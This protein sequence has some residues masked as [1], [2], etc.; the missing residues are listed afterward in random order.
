[1]YIQVHYCAVI[2]SGSGGAWNVSGRGV[3]STSRRCRRGERIAF[4]KGAGAF[5]VVCL[6]NAEI[7]DACAVFVN[8]RRAD[9]HRGEAASARF[10]PGAVF[11]AVGVAHRIHFRMVKASHEEKHWS[12]RVLEDNHAGAGQRGRGIVVFVL[13]FDRGCPLPRASPA[14]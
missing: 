4:G 7:A 11:R 8:E 5:L 2:G 9:Q 10:H 14:T 6:E 12:R 3:S 13:Q 1:V